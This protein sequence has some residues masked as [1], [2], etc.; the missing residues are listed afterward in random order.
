VEFPISIPSN[1]TKIT[2]TS[3]AINNRTP[4]V[5]Q[6]KD[7]FGA[8]EDDIL[9]GIKES[10]ILKTGYD[11]NEKTYNGYKTTCF[12]YLDVTKKGIEKFYYVVFFGNNK[13]YGFMMCGNQDNYEVD[14]QELENVLNNSLKIN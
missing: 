4:L 2:N 6:V 14:K 7:T 10:L 8:N 12:E 5:Y 11:V 3:Y 9:F 13:V 1:W